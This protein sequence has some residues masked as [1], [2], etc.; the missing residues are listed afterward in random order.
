MKVGNIIKAQS[1]DISSSSTW[2]E[3][4]RRLWIPWKPIWF[5][6]LD[7]CSTEQNFLLFFFSLLFCQI[8]LR[9]NI[10]IYNSKPY[11][12]DITPMTFNLV[13]CSLKM[14]KMDQSIVVLVLIGQVNFQQ[15]H[16]YFKSCHVKL[17]T[18]KLLV[19]LKL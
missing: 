13:Y 8:N 12:L 9:L 17:L 2:T 14:R 10:L 6:C 5:R 19:T 4:S 11:D 15:V 16:I 7:K 1:E 3:P 18:L